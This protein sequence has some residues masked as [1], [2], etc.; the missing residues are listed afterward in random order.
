MH[1]FNSRR[2][3]IYSSLAAVLWTASP[4]L[5]E[6]PPDIKRLYVA[7]S[8]GVSAVPSTSELRVLAGSKIIGWLVVEAVD[9]GR[10][11]FFSDAP[12]VNVRGRRYRTRPWPKK[13]LGPLDVQLYKVEPV[14]P[15]QSIYDNTGKMEHAWHPELRAEHP[16]RWHWCSIDYEETAVGQSGDAWS[17]TLT[18]KPTSGVAFQDYGT[19]RYA[20]RVIWRGHTYWTLGKEHRDK[21]GLMPGLATVRVR[22]DNTAVGYMTELMNVPYVYGSSTT[23]GKLRDHQ[24]FTKPSV[25]RRREI[26][27]ASY[28]Q[29]LRDQENI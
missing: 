7:L 18:S 2:L 21:S 4:A 29:G 1:D 22:R 14:I 16:D 3:L 9:R 25:E 5:A 28:I 19:M 26:Q 12:S 10:T 27:K 13:R 6:R 24:A 23:T 11:R 8:D 15:Q 17:W 20:A